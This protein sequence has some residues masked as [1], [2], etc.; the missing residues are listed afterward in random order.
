VHPKQ[1]GCTDPFKELAGVG[2]AFKLAHALLGELPDELLDLAAIGTIADLVP[3][4]DEN[5]LIATLGLERLRR[6]NRLGLK[7]LIKLSGGD[8]GEANEETVGFQLAPR[9]NAVGRIEQ[10]D[11]AVH[12]L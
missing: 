7:E 3:L 8:I 5:R 12:L 6:T 9:L 4:H 1:P 2:V 11:P 10:A